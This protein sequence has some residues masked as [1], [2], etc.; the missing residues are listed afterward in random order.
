MVRW[1]KRLK[2]TQGHVMGKRKGK[3]DIIFDKREC[4][5]LKFGKKKNI[6]KYTKIKV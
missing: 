3:T 1:V 2:I 6:E 4:D 5:V